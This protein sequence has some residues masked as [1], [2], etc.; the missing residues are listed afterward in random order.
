[1]T[2]N[3]I[4]KLAIVVLAFAL[5]AQDA[6]GQQITYVNGNATGLNTGDSWGNAFT[7]L[8]SALAD[9]GGE[10]WVAA[11]RYTPAAAGG[12]RSATFQLNTGHALYGGFVGGELTRDARDPVANVTALSGDLLGDDPVGAAWTNMTDNSYHVVTATGATGIVLDGFTISRGNAQ[13]SIGGNSHG[14]GLLISS[15]GLSIAN[16][17]IKENVA[18]WSAGMYNVDS[19][20]VITGS[21]FSD[22][23]AFSGRGGAIYHVTTAGTSA[24]FLTIKDSQFVR[25][26]AHSTSRSGDAGAI[27]SDFN[28]PLD[29]DNCLFD[30]NIACWRFTFGNYATGGGAILIFG[31]GTTIRNS[32]FRSNTAHIGGALWIARTATVANCL[33]IGNEAIRQGDG[34][35]DYG[36]YAGAVYCTSKSSTTFI[37]CTFHANK[38]RNVGGIWASPT[39]TIVNSILWSNISTEV[40][41][42]MLDQQ[43]SG[44]PIIKYS[45]V[46]GLFTAAPGEQ[47]PDPNNYP[48]TVAVDPIFFD[49]DGADNVLGN[50]DDDLR[51]GSGS[52]CIDAG[53]NSAV[54]AL[55]TAGLDEN[56]R[57]F[58]D[59][60]SV[61]AGVGV[62]PIVDMGAYEFGPWVDYGGNAFPTASFVV[63]QDLARVTLEDFSTDTDGTIVEWVWDFGDNMSSTFQS[64]QHTYAQNGN[65][66]ITL[67][68][69]DSGGA[70]HRS[71]PQLVSVTSYADFTLSITSPIARATVSNYVTLKAQSTNDPIVEQVNF[72]DNGVFIAK[73]K[74]APFEIIW[75]TTLV[76]EGT[77][78]ITAKANYFSEVEI[79]APPVMI[80][81]DNLTPVITSAPF[82]STA[83][84]G[85]TFTYQFAA[86]GVP[87]PTFS[88]ISGPVGMTVDS[89]SGLISFAPTL[90]QLHYSYVVKARATNTLGSDEQVSMVTVVDTT[91]PSVP[92]GTAVVNLTTTSATLTWD[93]ATDNVGVA[94][95]ELWYY[96]KIDRFPGHWILVN[97]FVL[98]TSI[99]VSPGTQNVYGFKYA[100]KSIDTSGN[101]S[102]FSATMLFRYATAPTLTH[103]PLNEVFPVQ[104]TTSGSYQIT[105]SGNPAPTVEL[106]TPPAGHGYRCE[107]GSGTIVHRS[108]GK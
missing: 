14:A 92:L 61:D 25:N 27:W 23:N 21:N 43:L 54:T 77:H 6:W 102:G 69:R 29:I 12:A 33:F 28:A 95:Y 47:A 45:C 93:A 8:Q 31:D 104:A 91:P 40:G 19:P 98:G 52:P 38:A 56:L 67:T 97:P 49:L 51:L 55:V 96:R 37:G 58:D 64:P 103:F 20:T 66:E 88:I 68:V 42:T 4:G 108:G 22:N 78:T 7:D 17:T 106:I 35:Y 59:P 71:A 34:F 60:S 53:N 16:C 90:D 75:N 85:S 50:L 11:G 87:S 73:T 57:F 72:Y 3:G 44:S 5:S 1:M 70:T 105:V 30:R 10:V 100:V 107:R 74:V 82:D 24:T 9:A 65:Y 83:N 41:A 15:S 13:S 46:K 80:T 2:G 39:T 62:A 26:Q 84:A 48:G 101:V 86:N 99:I 18:S 81:V 76:A 79:K 36:G 32:V 94:G 63:T 89:V